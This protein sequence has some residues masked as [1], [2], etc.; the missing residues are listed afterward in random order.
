M[1]NPVK[2]LTDSLYT[3]ISSL[4][5]SVGNKVTKMSSPDANRDNNN[6]FDIKR[7]PLTIGPEPTIVKLPE[8]SIRLSGLEKQREF[9][10]SVSQGRYWIDRELGAGG[11][12]QVFLAIDKK[13][14]RRVAIKSIKTDQSTSRGMVE[15]FYRELLTTGLFN[16]NN[17]V[18]VYDYEVNS[19][20][21]YLVMEYVDGGTLEQL[22]DGKMLVSRI[23]EISVQIAL[24]LEVA[25]AEK[26]LHRD[27]KPSNI[28]MTKSGIPKLCDFGIAKRGEESTGGK[29][30]AAIGTPQYMAPE[31]F[32]SPGSTDARSD[33]YGLGATLYRL[34]TGESPASPNFSRLSKKSRGLSDILAKCLDNDPTKRFQTATELKQALENQCQREAAK[35]SKRISTRLQAGECY[36]CGEQNRP[37]RQRCSACGDKLRVKC[38]TCT[39]DMPVWDNICDKCGSAQ[40]YLIE[41][42]WKELENM[43]STIDML[44]ES[45]SFSEAMS[46]IKR[47][48]P[49]SLDPRFSELLGW[50]SNSETKLIEAE[51]SLMRRLSSWYVISKQLAEQGR[52]EEALERESLL[53]EYPEI[54]K[55]LIISEHKSSIQQ[56]LDT[57]R[58]REKQ[59]SKEAVAP[60]VQ[61]TLQP[62]LGTKPRAV[63]R[64]GFFSN[65]S[66]KRA[67]V[68]ST[69]GASS[70][71]FL[72][73]FYMFLTSSGKTGNEEW[74][75]WEIEKTLKYPQKY[76]NWAIAKLTAKIDECDALNSKMNSEIRYL[77]AADDIFTRNE[78][79]MRNILTRAKSADRK[80]VLE[81]R[82]PVS[83]GGKTFNKE[84]LSRLIQLTSIYCDSSVPLRKEKEDSI[85]LLQL[86]IRDLSG[87]VDKLVAVRKSIDQNL[88]EA[89]LRDNPS[90]STEILTH[91][92][93]INSL[94]AS[95]LAE[96]ISVDLLRVGT[97]RAKIEPLTD[98][99]TLLG[100]GQ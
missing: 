40:S 89:S 91:R 14:D 16:H 70:L 15:R 54:V 97:A 94:L 8:E 43:Q 78:Q 20:P 57:I 100:K 80:A 38:L 18:R 24:A 2:K 46:L 69:L 35:N 86:R 75:D 27:I 55:G 33:I 32:R 1:F 59:K 42:R 31:Q 67:L 4:G 23:L 12:G 37:D 53:H 90:S 21:P 3:S 49:L 87:Y 66:P 58:K 45:Y 64:E 6:P 17:I 28:L 51:S 96:T 44:I 83:F 30:S 95:S 62:L 93:Q 10:W 98:L 7:Q 65:S 52:Y 81:K 56:L 63:V 71:A 25:H 72:V 73:V 79:D 26:V 22:C 76:R 74:Q 85:N 5:G 88:T 82:W 41:R 11:M 60:P 36:N 29:T 92:E 47:Y 34:A 77:T 9:F 84:E 39:S 19:H 61:S 50:L 13:F 99:K 68:S 48:Q